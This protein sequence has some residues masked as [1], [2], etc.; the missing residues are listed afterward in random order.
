MRRLTLLAIVLSVLC[1]SLNV[2]AQDLT[3]ARIRKLNLSKKAVY[4]DNGIFHNGSTKV[5]SSIK[6][7]RHSFTAKEG[8]ERIVFDFSSAQVPRVYGNFNSKDKKLYIDFF[9]TS[10]DGA[11]KSFGKT[12]FVEEIKF[13]PVSE[14]SL[15]LEMSL[16]DNV[17][18]DIFYLENPGRL[19]VDVKK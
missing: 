17:V 18:I 5:V 15:S 10:L 3:K 8:Y 2:F 4:I 9:D 7:M 16:K 14:E 1:I 19:V 11:V 13:F 12:R 6:A